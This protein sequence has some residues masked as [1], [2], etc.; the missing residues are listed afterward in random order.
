M[1]KTKLWRKGSAW[2]KAVD[3]FTARISGFTNIFPQ[4]NCDKLK[5]KRLKNPFYNPFGNELYNLPRRHH[6]GVLELLHLSAE[7]ED[8]SHDDINAYG[9][10]VAVI[11]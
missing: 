11:V 4:K 10:A 1:H 5:I 9:N 2:K 7:I 8:F 6:H 3:K